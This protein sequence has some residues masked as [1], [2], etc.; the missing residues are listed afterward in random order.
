[1]VRAYVEAAHERQDYSDQR[2]WAELLEEARKALHPFLSD[3]HRYPYNLADLEVVMTHLKLQIAKKALPIFNAKQ[4][5][6][7]CN[8]WDER[9][10]KFGTIPCMRSGI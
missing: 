3:E 2:E 1:L 7:T 10:R 4:I 5:S 9:L 8:A 6:A